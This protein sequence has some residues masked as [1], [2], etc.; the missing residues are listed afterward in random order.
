M[1]KAKLLCFFLLI[2]VVGSVSA[3]EQKI[4]QKVQAALDWK[5]PHNDC[6]EPKMRGVG[7]GVINDEGATDRKSVV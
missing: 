5:L 7:T 4:H 6:K 1:T 3:E 2:T